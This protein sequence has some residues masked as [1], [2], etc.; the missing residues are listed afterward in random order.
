MDKATINAFLSAVEEAG[1]ETYAFSVDTPTMLY[2]NKQNSIIVCDDSND[3]AYCFRDNSNFGSGQYFENAPLLAF[4][5][6]YEDIHE[7][8]LGCSYEKMEK[9]IDA[10]GLNVTDEQKKLLIQIAGSS[11]PINPPTG[12][13]VFKE[14]TQEEYD[15]LTEEEKEAYDAAK[16]EHDRKKYGMQKRQLVVE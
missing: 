4:G 6:K 13:Y 3:I 11:R 7:V 15:A 5:A 9:F 14:L 2:N 8:R 1:I 16:Y 12:D 10:L